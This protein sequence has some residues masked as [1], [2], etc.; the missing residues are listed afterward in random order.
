MVRKIKQERPIKCLLFLLCNL[1]KAARQIP[2]GG[3]RVK[4]Y[5]NIWGKSFLGIVNSK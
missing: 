5:K 3:E 1:D 2:K 4:S